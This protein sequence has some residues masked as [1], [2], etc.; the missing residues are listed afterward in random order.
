MAAPQSL[1]NMVSAKFAES[2]LPDI[3][4]EPVQGDQGVPQSQGSAPAPTGQPDVQPDQNA[5]AIQPDV[6]FLGIKGLGDE[7]TSQATE[8][9][10][11]IPKDT[12]VG[13]DAQ[14]NPITAEAFHGK[15]AEVQKG[16]AEYK[17]NAEPAI[18][19]LAENAE[20]LEAFASNDVNRVR[21]TL[22]EIGKSYGIDF[23]AQPSSNGRERDP[24]TGRFTKTGQS[25]STIDLEKFKEEYGEDSPAYQNAVA[26]QDANARIE[27]LQTMFDG[28]TSTAQETHQ[29]QVIEQQLNSLTT[30]W[31]EKG[32]EGIN[33]QAAKALVG[34]SITP[35]MAMQLANLPQIVKFLMKQQSGRPND[36]TS[37][38]SA[39][40]S[41]MRNQGKSLTERIHDKFASLPN[42]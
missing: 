1:A 5:A 28:L 11:D 2:G 39:E 40:N 24:G 7:P 42:S 16:F 38:L 6:S 26:L 13:K 37:N 20:I 23:S 21:D 32:V 10:L 25:A 9:T 15:F 31:S 17:Q 33:N 12:V 27:K 3:G 30:K 14:G 41:A 19:F 29:A 22:V 34:Q 8:F 18:Q 4:S 35:E 36:P